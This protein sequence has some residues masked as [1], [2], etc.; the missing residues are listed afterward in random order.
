MFLFTAVA[1]AS[2]YHG[3][4]Y[5][6]GREWVLFCCVFFSSSSFDYILGFLFTFYFFFTPRSSILVYIQ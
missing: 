1:L 2:P 5:T 6:S 3:Y 4:T